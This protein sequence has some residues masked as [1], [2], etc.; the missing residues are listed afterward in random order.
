M[1]CFLKEFFGFRLNEMTRK[2]QLANDECRQSE[3]LYQEIK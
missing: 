2:L 1:G 3:H